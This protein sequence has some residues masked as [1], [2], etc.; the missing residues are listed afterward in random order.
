MLSLSPPETIDEPP[1]H[2]HVAGC[3]NLSIRHACHPDILRRARVHVNAHQDRT[4]P[5]WARITTLASIKK[6]HIDAP[7]AHR[8][9]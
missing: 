7:I 5:A 8:R 2:R 3:V 9:L 4:G 1:V 6:Q